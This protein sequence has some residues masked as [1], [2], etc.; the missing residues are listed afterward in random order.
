MQHE[1]RSQNNYTPHLPSNETLRQTYEP[2][3]VFH[4]LRHTT[5]LF[6]ALKWEHH[7]PL[8]AVFLSPSPPRIPTKL[9][10]VSDSCPCDNCWY[11]RTMKRVGLIHH[12]PQRSPQF[13]RDVNLRKGV[14]LHTHIS[15]DAK[16]I[17]LL[18]QIIIISFTLQASPLVLRY[19]KGWMYV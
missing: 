17:H 10:P 5:G 14:H 2:Q 11:W 9:M 6:N 1:P 8:F 4:P 13:P 12:V 16:T 3:A 15:P 7:H 18:E 19:W